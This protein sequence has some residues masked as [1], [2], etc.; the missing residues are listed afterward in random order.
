M[1]SPVMNPAFVLI[2]F[3]HT[4]NMFPFGPVVESLGWEMSNVSEAIPLGPGLCIKRVLIVVCNIFSQYFD[5]MLERFSTKRRD[6]GDVQWQV[7]RD[8]LTRF[9]LP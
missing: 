1:F 9:D 6:I 5:L 8:N 7:Q 4:F 2:L 3:S